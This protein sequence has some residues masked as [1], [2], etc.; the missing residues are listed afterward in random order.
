M[1]RG[2]FDHTLDDKGRVSLPVK[3]REILR[4]YDDNIIITTFDS[5]LYVYPQEEWI[6]VEED[7][8]NRPAGKRD[9]RDLQRL[10]LSNATECTIDK[11]GRILIPPSLRTWAAIEKEVV[12]AGRI[13]HFEL[14]NRERFEQ[15]LT[16]AQN[17]LLNA[18]L[19]EILN[20]I[21]L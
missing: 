8:Y 1:F 18:D 12:L 11:Q 19:S 6:I 9:M 16:Q 14:W 20:D 3:F 7:L 4:K 10:L 13:K 15:V 2:K 21:K 5:C 17:N